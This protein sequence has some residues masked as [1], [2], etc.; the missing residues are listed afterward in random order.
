MS[1]A[2][3]FRILMFVLSIVFLVIAVNF[4]ARVRYG[5]WNVRVAMV[6][7]WILWGIVM[8]LSVVD[9]LTTSSAHWLW[10]KL[11]VRLTVWLMI[12]VIGLDDTCLLPQSQQRSSVWNVLLSVAIMATLFC[13][14]YGVVNAP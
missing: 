13:V 11:S 3:I 8:V 14:G 1:T 12:I 10:L 2:T 7:A 9:V 4:T 6:G 5:E